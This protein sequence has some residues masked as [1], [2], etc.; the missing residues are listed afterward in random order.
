LG[1]E[2][3]PDGT[4]YHLG[5]V[6]RYLREHHFPV[7]TT[8]FYAS[9][10]EALE[11]LFLFAFSVGR[12]S[13]AATFHLLFLSP[14]PGCWSRGAGASI[15]FGPAPARPCCFSL[16]GSRNRCTTAYVD[17]GEAVVVLALFFVLQVWR[18]ERND[19]MLVVAGMLAGFAAA[20]KYP[21]FLAPLYA[22]IVV[23]YVLRREPKRCLRGL[24]LIA[25]PRLCS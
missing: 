11:M 22:A 20:I 25:L 23:G 21:G 3:S 14:A 1:P 15:A 16:A 24:A 10:P 9:F 5:L 6:A 19:R 18:E 8:N 17:V 2:Y 7:I 4:A 12:H 13:A